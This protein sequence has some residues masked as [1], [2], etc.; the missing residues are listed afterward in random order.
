MMYMIFTLV[1][2]GLGVRKGGGQL[3]YTLA[4]G[5]QDPMVIVGLLCKSRT[6]C[7]ET[8]IG[9]C[10]RGI[11]QFG[12][13]ADI[14]MPRHA[15]VKCAFTLRMSRFSLALSRIEKEPRTTTLLGAYFFMIMRS[16]SRFDFYMNR[17]PPSRRLNMPRL[18]LANLCLSCLAPSLSLL[19]PPNDSNLVLPARSVSL[20]QR[21]DS[22]L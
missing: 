8:S 19:L 14:T 1:Y 22:G 15:A 17:V 20:C 13:L 9:R 2:M 4:I 6:L 3:L 10:I 16:C 12:T 18:A 21:I 11:E 5:V 7:Y